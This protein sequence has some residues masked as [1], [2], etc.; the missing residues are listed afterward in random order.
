MSK[1][2]MAYLLLLASLIIS[3]PSSALSQT[4]FEDDPDAVLV[5]VHVVG[6]ELRITE[7]DGVVRTYNSSS[8]VHIEFGFDTPM[9][10]LDALP[11][12]EEQYGT[13]MQKKVNWRLRTNGRDPETGLLRPCV[14]GFLCVRF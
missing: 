9:P 11:A 2:G 6:G 14:R 7:P 10:F 12:L 8:D 3:A 1:H 5:T 13:P 4:H